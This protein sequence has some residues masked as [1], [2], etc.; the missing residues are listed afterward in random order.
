[1]ARNQKTKL[2]NRRKNND[3]YKFYVE[4]LH[5]FIMQSIKLTN[6]TFIKIKH[7]YLNK[8][9]TTNKNRRKKGK[10][11]A[12]FAK[13][14]DFLSDLPSFSR[15]HQEFLKLSSST[16]IAI[17]IILSILCFTVIRHT[18]YINQVRTADNLKEQYNNL[19]D[20]VQKAQV[21]QQRALEQSAPRAPPSL[22]HRSRVAHRRGM[23]HLTGPPHVLRGPCCSFCCGPGVASITCVTTLGSS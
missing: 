8:N 11:A 5:Q 10:K 23:L 19:F 15:I 9:Q 6:D 22:C 16:L 3:P 18:I 4:K 13:F 2:K 7:M 20:N 14:N 21:L 17:F 12:N 1:M